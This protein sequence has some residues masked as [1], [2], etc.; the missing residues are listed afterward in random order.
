VTGDTLVHMQKPAASRSET[1]PLG[2]AL[3][4]DDPRAHSRWRA[5]AARALLPLA[6]LALG[7]DDPKGDGGGDS[8]NPGASI[9]FGDI[10]GGADVPSGAMSWSVVL[11]AYLGQVT[12]GGETRVV[13]SPPD[14]CSLVLMLGFDGKPVDGSVLEL[15][16]LSALNWITISL[17]GGPGSECP[18]QPY[19]RWSSEGGEMSVS[20]TR[21]P[22]ILEL[23]FADVP[24]TAQTVPIINEPDNA[25]QGTFTITGSVRADAY[26]Y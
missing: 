7:C 25:A 23:T 16:Q 4:E 3:D 20:A 18:S 8:D 11:S 19:K 12:G 15:G 26:V 14:E 24:M 2:R 17:D 6:I 1:S 22:D 9:T 10:A 5:R 21:D 13:A